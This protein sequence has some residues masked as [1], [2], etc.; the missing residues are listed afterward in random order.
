MYQLKKLEVT[1]Y[2]EL[3]KLPDP[4]TF[5]DGSRVKTAADWKRRREELIKTAVE[6]QYGTLPPE[7]EFLEVEPLYTPGPG[8]LENYRIITGTRACPVSFVMQVQRPKKK[9][10]CPAVI[11]GDLCWYGPQDRAIWS[12]F[13]EAGIIAAG[14]NR[15]E[16]VPDIRGAKR[17]S[18]LQR[19]YPDKTFGGIAAWAWGYWRCTDALIKLGLCD[20]HIVYPG[21]SR[22]GKTALVAGAVDE[23][24]WITNPEAP[25][26]GGSLYRSRMRAITEDG[27]ERRSEEYDDI[28]K[29]FPDWFAPDAADYIGRVPELSYDIHELKALV[30]PRIFFNSEAKSD[31]WAGPLQ[32]YQ[33]NVAAREVYK[34]LGCPENI[35]WYWRDGYHDQN[36]E[37]FGML[38]NLIQNR[39]KGEELSE[40]FGYIPFDEPP[41]IFDWRAPVRED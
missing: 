21:L 12:M 23:R 16:I 14:F 39:L 36:A 19:A 1:F 37:D 4:F 32:A 6:A 3:A 38:L 20:E 2:E 28:V 13:T 18:A 9:E 22:G 5:S 35:L 41:S 30:A 11:N 10:P 8:K 7:P 17:T 26:A 25:C 15:T 34:F 33:S 31:L 40:K 29:T 24:A 27:A